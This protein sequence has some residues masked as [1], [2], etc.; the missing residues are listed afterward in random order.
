MPDSAPPIRRP[1]LLFSSLL[2][3]YGDD[4]GYVYLAGPLP[5][6]LT[7]D[8]L[9]LV[10]AEAGKLPREREREGRI[11]SEFEGN[12]I[13]AKSEQKSFLSFPDSRV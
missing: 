13:R 6:R 1:P 8:D 4:E 3:T 10:V 12:R 11:K 7:V 2:L 9:V 5:P